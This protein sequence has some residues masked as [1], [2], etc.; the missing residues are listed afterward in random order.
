MIV[1]DGANYAVMGILTPVNPT[2]GQVLTYVAADSQWEP[3]SLSALGGANASQLRSVSISTGSASPKPRQVLAYNEANGD[4]ESTYVGPGPR[5]NWHGFTVDPTT[6]TAVLGYG[7]GWTVQNFNITGVNATATEPFYVKISSPS[8][9]NNAFYGWSYATPQITTGIFRYAVTR[10][11]LGSTGTHAGYY[12]GLSSAVGPQLIAQ[13]ASLAANFVGFRFWNGTDTHWQA[14]VGKDAT[15]ITLVDTGITPDTNSH[16][17]EIFSDG[18]NFHFYIDGTK[19]ATISVTDTNAPANTTLL[20]QI[21]W[22]SNQNGATVIPLSC[23]Y[24]FWESSV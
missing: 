11:I 24:A 4:W 1:S 22:L 18:T 14:Y 9:G 15:H 7:G 5:A 10:C 17:Y 21:C 3:K 16:I 8:T 12:L 19:V 23:A 6:M 13:S 2:D 20:G